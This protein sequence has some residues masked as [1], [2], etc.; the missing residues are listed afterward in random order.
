MVPPVTVAAAGVAFFFHVDDFAARGDFTIASYDAAAAQSSEAEKPNQT[1]LTPS[2]HS[3]SNSHAARLACRA[4]YE[5]RAAP[6]FT[7]RLY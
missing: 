1:H 3:L 6:Y 7:Y 5:Q 2:F 4:R